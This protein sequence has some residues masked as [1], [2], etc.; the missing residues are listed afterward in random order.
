MPD[1]TTAK[2]VTDAAD[3]VRIVGEPKPEIATKELPALDVHCRHFISLCPFLC[4]STADAAGNQ[5]VSPRGDPPGF[6]RVLDDRTIL[7]PDRKGNRRVDTMRNILENPNVGLL[8]MLPGVEEV[9]R[10]NGKA[11]LTEDPAL[12]AGSAVNGSVPALGIIVKIDDVFF[13]CA[14]AVIRSK[15][16]DPETPIQ[17]T[18]FPTFGEIVR[19]QRMPGGD[20]AEIDAGLQEN[21]RSTL[22]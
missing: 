21:Y 1:D 20:P 6:V 5:D 10:I 22:Y 4:I 7:I 15:L 13:H 9:V 3:L 19:D 16:W 12:L 17:R 18:D 11:T 2:T 8:L 14:K